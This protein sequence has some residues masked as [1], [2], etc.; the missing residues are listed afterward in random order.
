MSHYYAAVSA[1]IFG[2]VALA[3]IARLI[4][5]WKVQIG[6]LAVPM[7]V[8]WI[9]LGVAALLAFWGLTQSVQ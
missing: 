5:R 3:H 6:S 2:V 8:S 9:G 1:F 7:S 4:N